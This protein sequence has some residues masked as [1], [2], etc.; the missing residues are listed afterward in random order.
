M[1][2]ED[3]YVLARSRLD[4]ESARPTLARPCERCHQK[5]C[6]HPPRENSPR[7]RVVIRVHDAE[8]RHERSTERL[9][10]N[11]RP[12]FLRVAAEERLQNS[13]SRWRKGRPGILK[14][15]LEQCPRQLDRQ[16]WSVRCSCSK[17]T[18][19]QVR[20]SCG[21]SITSHFSMFRA[22]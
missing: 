7:L 1:D 15:P 17:A 13:F 4:L 10:A 14:I 11:G 8:R 12:C 5:W 16:P 22:P 9:I 2:E 18:A 21:H 20:H 19:N 6:Q 3:L